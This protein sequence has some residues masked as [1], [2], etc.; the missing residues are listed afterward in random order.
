MFEMI[1]SAY[2]WAFLQMASVLG[3]GWAIVALSFVC[4]A[5][6]APLMKAV[7][8]I[9]RRESDYQSVID[10]QVAAI[11]AKYASD[12]DRHLH[13]QRLY[14]RY[15]YSPLSPVKKVLPLFVQIPFLL[16]TYYMLKGTAEL[17]GVKFLFLSDLG[18][19]D[20]LFTVPILKL[21]VLPLV[22]TGVNIV[23]VFAT[24]GFTKKDWTQAITIALLFLV[25]LYTAP[26]ALLL[27]WTLN[28]AITMV[29]T[30]VA[31]KGEGMRLLI[32]R[33]IAFRDIPRALIR[34]LTPSLLEAI[35]LALSLVSL[36]MALMVVM[37]VWFFNCYVSRFLMCPTILLAIAVQTL[38]ARR[39]RGRFSILAGCLFGCTLVLFGGLILVAALSYLCPTAVQWFVVAYRPLQWFYALAGFWAVIRMIQAV[40]DTKIR[41]EAVPVF[42]G[43]CHWLLL[44]AILALHYSFSSELVKLPIDGVLMLTVKLVVPAAILAVL[45]VLMFA[46]RLPA[47]KVCRVGFVFAVATYLV[48]MISLESGKFLSHG[49]NL[50][51]R[52]FFIAIVSLIA[53]RL[54]RRKPVLIAIL[55]MF[56]FFGG[57]AICQSFTVHRDK[58]VRSEM[59]DSEAA[60]AFHAAKVVR[61]NNVC[62]LV[63]DGYAHDRVLADLKIPSRLHEILLP[64]GFVRYDAYSVGSDTV[65]SMGNSF[66]IGGVT[67]GSVRSMMA[68]NNPFCD[69]LKRSGYTTSYLLCAYDM[70][71][72]G[73][74]MPGD[75]YFPVPQEVA[76]LE[77]VLYSCV[78][79]GYLSQAANTFNSY[80]S[81][82]WLAEKR[83]ILKDVPASRNFI[84]A[85]S[86]WPGHAVANEVYRR[87][88]DEE[89]T[90]YAKRVARA[91]AELEE[92]LA[93]LLSKNDDTLIIVASDHGSILVLPPRGDFGRLD[94]LD[95]CGIQLY[96]RWPKGYQPTLKLDCL[97][98]VFLET[99]IFLTGD[100]SLARFES[101]GVS[102]PIE[103]PLKAPAGTIKRGIIQNGRDKGKRLFE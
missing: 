15:G 31:K 91:D 21:N 56:A 47:R 40:C 12:M 82:Q 83:R 65:Q 58:A 16:L 2:R 50:V 93:Q 55:L 97:T 95:R 90:A 46:R 78:L 102:L 96:V 37:H 75:F 45:L 64:R 35:S 3:L 99:M 69:F 27:Y 17:N 77:N 87:S 59:A 81:E 11:K 5:L 42:F 38:A 7:A 89:I 39:E 33:I 52:L 94:L 57:N 60:R 73:E 88:M 62:L 70:P 9:V 30:L 80:S 22:M 36:Y 63:Y 4:S 19:P 84:Y 53:L 13:I 29:R 71:G 54:N 66:A 41:S 10:P 1:I 74:R 28:N 20:A 44:P 51:V 101:E 34:A 26:S 76:R 72:R 79:Q 103:A 6:M 14:A 24:P 32:S 8:G 49:S 43:E 100:A 92:D 23:T 68:G 48:P 67:Q 61:T 98:N 85:H 25:L 18:Q 86:E